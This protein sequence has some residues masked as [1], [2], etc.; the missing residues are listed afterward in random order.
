ARWP[1]SGSFIEFMMA[2][3]MVAYLPDDILVKV[4]RASMGVSLEARVP[5]LDH[6]VAEFAWQL[7]LDLKVRDGQ[8]KW[9]LRQL[10]YRHVP[11]QLIDRPKQGFAVP[12]DAW[13]RGPLRAWAEE[14]LAE[15]RLR[16]EGYLDPTDIRVRWQEHLAGTRRGHEHLWHVLMFQAWLAEE[17]ASQRPPA[18][19]S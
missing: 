8:R 12:I 16:R 1:R 14:L 6:R 11:R 3:D 15:S 9:L 4:D 17:G 2:M 5:L 19:L 10:L 7:P 13:L 18:A